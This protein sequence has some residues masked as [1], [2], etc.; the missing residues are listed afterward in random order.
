MADRTSNLSLLQQLMQTKKHTKHYD[1][2]CTRQ[3]AGTNL[4]HSGQ[5]LELVETDSLVFF[6]LIHHHI[7]LACMIQHKHHCGLSLTMDIPTVMS[8]SRLP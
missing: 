6:I 1:C 2:T 7:R 5:L 4:K 3:L 8:L